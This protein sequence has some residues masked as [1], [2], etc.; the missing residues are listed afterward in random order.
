MKRKI[1]ILGGCGYTGTHLVEYLLNKNYSVTVIDTQWFG[2][3]L[4]KNKDL[5]IVKSDIRNIKDMWREIAG[6]DGKYMKYKGQWEKYKGNIKAIWRTMKDMKEIWREKDNNMNFTG[7]RE[8]KEIDKMK[9]YE[10]K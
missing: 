1:L 2:C 8:M 3:F 6:N 5:T 7:K 9:E 4:K 10:A